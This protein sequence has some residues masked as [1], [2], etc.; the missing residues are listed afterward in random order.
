MISIFFNKSRNDKI[1]S[2]NVIHLSLI[3]FEIK[4]NQIYDDNL[5]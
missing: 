5:K 3:H 2:Y 1:T 4:V